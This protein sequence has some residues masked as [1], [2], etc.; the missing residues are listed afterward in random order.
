MG[1][2][3]IVLFS[4]D[5]RYADAFSEYCG[6]HEKERISVMTF[7]NEESLE[8]CISK[9]CM[10]VLLTENVPEFME[11][12]KYCG[13]I[14]LLSETR[15]VK[16]CIHPSIYKYQRMDVILRQLHEHLAEEI[17]NEGKICSMDE[18]TPDI[19]GCFSPCYEQEREQF[20]RALAEYLGKHGRTLFINMAVFTACDADGGEGLS[21][22]LYYS[23]NS[24]ENVLSYRLPALSR[25]MGTYE[26]LPGVKNYLDLYD[27]DNAQAE[28]L[29]DKITELSEYKYIIVDMSMIGDAAAAI[30]EYCKNI[31]MPVPSD[32][33]EDRINH[34]KRDYGNGTGGNVID[35]IN[36]VVLPE[37]WR[38]NRVRRTG[39]VRETY[40]R[41]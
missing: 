8:S 7:T 37:W 6:R 25:S 34:F 22:L 15:Y 18:K 26:S 19:I 32:A 29:F 33:E 24:E 40:E 11:T 23:L 17:G 5:S 41:Y 14:V 31:F 10:D 35:R 28:Q 1:R 30:L 36:C 9:E 21:E 20:A 3:R 2:A 39:W 38:T 12:D 27:L 16:D 13:K 4:R